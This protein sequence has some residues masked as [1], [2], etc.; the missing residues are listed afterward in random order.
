MIFPEYIAIAIFGCFSADVLS[1]NSFRLFLSLFLLS[2][3]VEVR[4]AASI[5][6]LVTR[7]EPPI[8]PWIKRPGDAID[9]FLI[10]SFHEEEELLQPYRNYS[11]SEYY[12]PV[13][14][15]FPLQTQFTGVKRNCLYC[16]LNHENNTLY[17]P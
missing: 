11:R 7:S 6:V 9:H 2:T 3:R 1:P 16:G 10:I 15:C 5:S 17:F 12:P 13:V 14:V 8:V 4:C